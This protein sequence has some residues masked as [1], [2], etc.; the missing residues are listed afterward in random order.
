MP[1]P[2][3][4]HDGN[5]GTKKKT[6]EKT[7]GDLIVT[8]DIIFPRYLTG[9]QKEA[10]RAVMNDEDISILEDVIRLAA[11]GDDKRDFEHEKHWTRWCNPDETCPFD[12][13]ARLLYT[14]E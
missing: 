9:A 1:I 4:T 14:A 2:P 5:A 3:V 7:H 10:L 11:A 8:F 13:L 6:E 12:P